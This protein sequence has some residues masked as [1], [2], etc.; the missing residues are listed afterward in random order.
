MGYH[1]CAPG[2]D[3]TVEGG[4]GTCRAY[5]CNINQQDDCDPNQF[6]KISF[7]DTSGAMTDVFLCD[8]CDDCEL[9]TANTCPS[10]QGC[11]LISAEN[12]CHGCLPSGNAQV[13]E[14][15]QAANTCP[16]G[17]GCFTTE[18][19]PATCIAYCNLKQPAP[20]P[21]NQQCHPVTGLELA[22][23]VGVCL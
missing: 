16:S 15:C 13:G 9:S 10:G 4:T 6:C 11:Y 14:A 21:A 20:C 2:L 5:C 8:S 12:N 17:Q 22:E 19:G 7:Q 18:N 3:C 23:G 1:D